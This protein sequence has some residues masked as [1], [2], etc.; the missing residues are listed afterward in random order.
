MEPI[1]ANGLPAGND[2]RVFLNPKPF[3]FEIVQVVNL[4]KPQ[5]GERGRQIAAFTGD[6]LRE[7]LAVRAGRRLFLIGRMSVSS[8]EVARRGPERETLLDFVVFDGLPG[9]LAVFAARVLVFCEITRCLY[10]SGPIVAPDALNHAVEVDAPHR[11]RAVGPWPTHVTN[12][13]VV[14]ADGELADVLANTGGYL[15]HGRP[16]W[17]SAGGQSGGMPGL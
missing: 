1:S 8:D 3:A 7:L 13:A 10:E 12:G 2:R 15:L 16:S 11:G 17:A 5:S 14:L 9:F 6:A 4:D